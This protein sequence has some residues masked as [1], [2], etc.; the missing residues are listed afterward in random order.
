MAYLCSNTPGQSVEVEN[1]IQD[2]LKRESGREGEERERGG[3]GGGGEGEGMFPLER[4]V[5]HVTLEM[6]E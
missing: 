5:L 3:G 2:G 6:L 4:S 1:D